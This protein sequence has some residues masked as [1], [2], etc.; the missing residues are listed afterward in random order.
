MIRLLVVGDGER[1]A[2]TIPRLVEQVLNTTVAESFRPWA[3]LHSGGRGYSRKLKYAARQA[4][5]AR[6][7]GLVADVDRDRSH[8]GERL[9]EM[10]LGRQQDR[11]SQ[12]PFPTALGE[13]I[14]HGE[15]WLLDDSQAVREVLQLEPDVQIPTPTKTKNPKQALEDNVEK[16]NSTQDPRTI[17]AE[18]AKA[19]VP[20]RCVH[21]KETGFHA[22]AEEVKVEF[23]PLAEDP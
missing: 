16:S 15:A 20:N 23:G 8:P 2:A 9:R 6:M 12:P 7:N 22:F 19:L 21:A 14:P 5:L 10:R 17:W 13:A 18:I 11:N 4:Q 1:D 3:R